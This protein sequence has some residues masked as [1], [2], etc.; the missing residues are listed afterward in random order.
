MRDQ[1]GRRHRALARR[2]DGRRRRP[3]RAAG[4]RALVRRRCG[5]GART[6]ADRDLRA[7]PR[8]RSCRRSVSDEARAGLAETEELLR[9]LGH[10]V[11]RHE[12]AFGLAGNN[13]VARYLGGIHDDIGEVPHPERLEA[14]TRGFGRLGRAYAGAAS[15]AA[16][17]KPPARRRAQATGSGDGFDVVVTPTSA[18][19]RSRSAAGRARARCGP[20]S[21]MSRVYAFA[22][23]WNHTGQ[24][25]GV[26][27]GRLHAAGLPLSVR[28]SAARTT[29]RPDLARGPDRGRA[30][31]WATAVARRSRPDGTAALD[32]RQHGG[33]ARSAAAR[34]R[35]AGGGLRTRSPSARRSSRPSPGSRSKPLYTEEDLAERRRRARPRL[36]RRVPVHPR[37]LPVDVPR[38]AVDDAPV[39]RLRHRRGDQR[40]L[41]LPARPRPDR[42]LDRLRH[43][44]P[45]GPRLRPRPLARRGRRARAW[46]STRSTTWRRC[47]RAS[48]SARSR[49]R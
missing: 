44:D 6:A 34:P 9:S 2:R 4:A 12:P 47:S 49:P 5:V 13:F 28:W 43:A 11:D 48:R 16:R 21:A 23:I 8:G 3:R 33:R 20:C 39:R 17:R 30:P 14:R 22:P 19:R 38:A 37:R 31:R 10:E 32:S 46:R 40:A 27:P 26:G 35:V 24:P 36:P 41:P 7:R 25:V 1:D 18:R 29:R 45:D 42:A 15:S